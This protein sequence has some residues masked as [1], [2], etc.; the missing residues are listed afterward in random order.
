MRFVLL[1]APGSGKG[2]QAKKLMERY[3]IPEISTGE[4]LRK[5]VAA[6]TPLGKDAKGYMDRGELVPDSIVLGMVHD[7]LKREDCK[8]GYIIDGFPRNEAQA[9]ALD[10]MLAVIGAP[11]S[12]VVSIEVEKKE[13]IKRMSGR[14]ICRFCGQVFNVHLLPPAKEGVCDK[15]GGGLFQR[16]DDREETIRKRLSVY[17]SQKAPLI[18]YYEKKRIL[19]SITGSGSVSD[20]FKQVCDAV[21]DK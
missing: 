7:R 11:V 17:E 20:I 18:A 3:S 14:R 16:D 13:L 10:K 21:E 4:I 2:T 12:A 1:G 8:K 15:C 9:M 5:A 19:K 6:G